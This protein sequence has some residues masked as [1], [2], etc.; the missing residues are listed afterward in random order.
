MAHLTCSECKAMRD[1]VP[2]DYAGTLQCAH[3]GTILRVVTRNGLTVDV[4]RRKVELEIPEG[5]PDDLRRIL[6]DAVACLESECCAAS[7]VMARVFVEGL[8]SRAG[9]RGTL[10]EQIQTAYQQKVISD[11]AYH[12]AS[13]SRLMGNYGA[14][15]APTLMNL[16]PTEC[17]L[18][19]ELVR[20]LATNILASNVS[21]NH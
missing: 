14:H 5:L 4:R 19:L 11:Y 8:M 6:S 2:D 7:L 20:G 13:A 21:L 17:R 15:Y 18:V 12:L 3:C 1:S 10:A 9:F 16:E